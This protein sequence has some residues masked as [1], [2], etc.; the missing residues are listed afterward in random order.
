MWRSLA[1]ISR[2]WAKVRNCIYYTVL[3]HANQPPSCVS[4]KLSLAS[5][6]KDALRKE[7]I[8]KKAVLKGICPI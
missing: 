1:T 7:I 4:A 8:E 3:K 5:T 2:L 6:A